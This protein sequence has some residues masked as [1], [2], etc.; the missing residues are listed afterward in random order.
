[1]LA[2]LTLACFVKLLGLLKNG[3]VEVFQPAENGR[4]ERMIATLGEGEVFG[5]KA[6]LE[7]LPRGASVRARKAVDLLTISR[8]DFVAI[9]DKFPPLDAYFETL[10]KARYPAELPAS[11]SLV[12]HIAKPVTFPG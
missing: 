3:E 1:M 11:E 4:A 2:P 8:D 12:E 9:V 7:D 10:M 6:L 5:E